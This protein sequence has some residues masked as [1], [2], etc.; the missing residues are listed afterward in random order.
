ML[1]T[2]TVEAPYKALDFCALK[3]VLLNKLSVAP[4]P[5]ASLLAKSVE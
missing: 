5:E 3:A 2:C 4:C 1:D